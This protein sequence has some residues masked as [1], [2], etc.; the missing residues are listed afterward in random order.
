MSNP[1]R[2]TRKDT[3]QSRDPVTGA[4]T[5]VQLDAAQLAFERSMNTIGNELLRL[6]KL[7]PVPAIQARYKLVDLL[8]ETLS[9]ML[10]HIEVPV[11]ET[12]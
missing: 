10:P 12:V 7:G 4:L 11:E 8:L 9:K 1:K 5:V 3:R 6:D 2:W